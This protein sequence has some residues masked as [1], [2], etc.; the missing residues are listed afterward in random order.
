[1]T[2]MRAASAN[3]G[4]RA[5][6]AVSSMAAVLRAASVGAISGMIAGIIAGGIGGRVAM[7]IAAITATDAEQGALTEAEEVVG[8]ISFDGTMGLIVFGGVFTGIFGGL[9]YAGM[10][11]WLSSLQ[12]WKGLAFGCVLLASLGW[13]VIERDN[14][15]FHT[16]GYATLNIAMFA[17][18]FIAFGVLVAPLFGF[19][20]R[21]LPDVTFS[22][23]GGF[24]LAA[25]V[26]G[27]ITLPPGLAIAIGTG[28]TSGGIFGLI[29]IYLV[30][31]L[32]VAA[33][34]IGRGPGGF[35]A[36]ADLHRTP[37]ALTLALVVFAVP[38][39]LGVV[40]DARAITHILG[41]A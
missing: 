13:T 11:P 19:L 28:G 32:P 9:M 22:L 36:L 27:A 34:L 31:E 20:D 30:A 38:V 17:A 1:M 26:L 24:G 35:T 23:A 25:R 33:L 16:F 39:A 40:L 18:I 21:V 14:F 4:N 12:G 10:R 5:A 29:P 2:T 41:E 7:R 15:D 6:A 8:V 37:V 3:E